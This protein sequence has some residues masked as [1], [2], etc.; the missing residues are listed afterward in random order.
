MALTDLVLPS[1]SIK[2]DG[3]Q[4]FTVKPLSFDDV[5]WL[6]NQ[7]LNDLDDAVEFFRKQGLD[8]ATPPEVF[9]ATVHKI[10]VELIQNYPA[11][12]AR[13]IACASGDRGDGAVRVAGQLPAPVQVDA[14]LETFRLTFSAPGGVK[15]FVGN[16]SAA[17]RAFS[18]SLPKSPPRTAGNTGST[19]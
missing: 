19:S 3:E 11:L 2:L 1:S 16:V 5:T 12:T 17:L 8:G 9:E 18:M 6:V 7:S 4:A 13:I 14:L 10:M 15:K